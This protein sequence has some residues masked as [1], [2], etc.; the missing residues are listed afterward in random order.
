MQHTT[1]CDIVQT[2][3]LMLIFLAIL[4]IAGKSDNDSKLHPPQ[5]EASK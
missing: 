3:L 1:K 5:W 2:V 4:G